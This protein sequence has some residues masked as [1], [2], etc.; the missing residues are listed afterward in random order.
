MIL[1]V[2]ANITAASPG[3]AQDW[4]AKYPPVADCRIS[5]THASPLAAV[6]KDGKADLMV[7][8]RR[9]TTGQSTPNVQAII[10]RVGDHAE[11]PPKP[12][13]DPDTSSIRV[14]RS[15]PPGQ[16]VLRVRGL[17]YYPRQDT[18]NVLPGLDTIRVALE[19]WDD[20]YRNANNCR[21]HTFRLPGQR[22]CVTDPKLTDRVM[23]H[24]RSFAAPNQAAPFKIPK[25]SRKEVTLVRDESVCERAGRAYGGATSPP[26]YVVVVRMGRLYM[27]YDPFEPLAAGEFDITAI[28]DS[29]W[30]TVVLLAG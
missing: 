5:L 13:Y 27:V 14:F 30:R 7:Q 10:W 26:R 17:G 16:Y 21:P 8:M 6:E 3:T 28:F 2:L 22:A 1:V 9:F 29:D 11:L 12:P 20:G 24:A 25:F 23:E 19:L 15:L 4:P 18:V